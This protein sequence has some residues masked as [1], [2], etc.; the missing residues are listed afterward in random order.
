MV[1]RTPIEEGK[2]GDGLGS[3]VLAPL[4]NEP[5][6][7]ALTLFA[8][9]LPLAENRKFI[10]RMTLG[11][12]IL[13]LI[14]ALLAPNKYTAVTKI[15]PPQQAQSSISSMLGQLG[16]LANLGG[17]SSMLGLKNPAE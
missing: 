10:S 8:L 7:G 12:A 2:Q 16:A 9:Y 6:S 5:D 15:L 11:A 1:T 13:G 4:S 14:V 3:S 17:G